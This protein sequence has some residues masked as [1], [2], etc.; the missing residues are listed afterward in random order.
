MSVQSFES[1]LAELQAMQDRKGRDY[2]TDSD[3]LANLRAS[4]DFG[5]LAWV[6]SIMRGNDKMRR[7]QAFVRKGVL[8][9]E[10]VEDSLL[11]LAV[12]AIHAL[13]LFREAYDIEPLPTPT[14]K[15]GV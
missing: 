12:Y 7:I 3:P 10:P 1:V 5:T 4:E 14:H 9:N 6:G 11:D 8:E 15:P 13:R 2:G